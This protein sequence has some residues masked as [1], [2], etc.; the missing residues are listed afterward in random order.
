MQA[1]ADA[2]AD[3]AEIR[4]AAASAAMAAAEERDR[5]S[6]RAYTVLAG[7]SLRTRG[8]IFECFLE[9]VGERRARWRRRA[10]RQERR[11]VRRRKK[12]LTSSFPSSNLSRP[13]PRVAGLLLLPFIF[14]NLHH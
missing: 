2:D 3:I 12:N 9:T 4:P 10:K 8:D 11:V 6:G 13:W 7:E 5:R 14:F 1:E